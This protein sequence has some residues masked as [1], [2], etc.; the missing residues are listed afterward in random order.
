MNTRKLIITQDIEN[1]YVQT[2]QSIIPHWTLYVG[3]DKAIW[4]AH[5]QEAEV[6]AGWRRD[7][8]ARCLQ[9]PSSLRWIQTWSAGVNEM[10]LKSCAQKA[11]YMTSA[12]GVH[13][14]P[15][16]E[17]IFA[18]M[19][20]YTRKIDTYVKQ[21]QVK[22]WHHGGL[23]LELHEKTIGIIGVGAIGQETGKIAKAFNMKVLG[24]RHSGKPDTYV[25]E[26]YIPEQLAQLLPKCDYVVNTLPLTPDTYHFFGDEAF[27]LMKQSAFFVNIG[28]GQTV[29]EPALIK[30]LQAGEIAGAGLDVFEEEPLNENS[31]LWKMDNVIITPHS[32]GSNENYSKRVI[33]NIL[34][35][36]LKHYIAHDAPIINVIDYEKGY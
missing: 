34:I 20:A 21:Q 23:K 29:D 32:A 6:I 28:R 33:E 35:P 30:A 3:K 2:I 26:M 4:E 7:F 12:N 8:E 11:I 22:K 18:L 16:S 36:N 13:A 1:S 9:A 5:V 15:I 27:R 25:D 14:Y 10:P 17:T 31:P 24:M 19:L